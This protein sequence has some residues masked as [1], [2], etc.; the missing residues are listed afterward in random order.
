MVPEIP[1]N[2]I[3]ETIVDLKKQTQKIKKILS[4]TKDKLDQFK[5]FLTL[6]EEKE[7]LIP[8]NKLEHHFF[9][10][11]DM[12]KQAEKKRKTIGFKIPKLQK[13]MDLIFKDVPII[14]D[15]DVLQNNLYKNK[16]IYKII[17]TLKKMEHLEIVKLVNKTYVSKHP[18]HNELFD[19]LINPY[20]TIYDV[21]GKMK[22]KHFQKLEEKIGEIDHNV[23]KK[24][25]IINKKCSI[26]KERIKYRQL[27]KSNNDKTMKKMNRLKNALVTSGKRKI[28]FQ[29]LIRIFKTGITKKMNKM[30]RNNELSEKNKTN[31][32]IRIKNLEQY[33]LKT[34]EEFL[35][36]ELEILS[37]KELKKILK[38]MN[39]EINEYLGKIKE[40][41]KRGNNETNVD[42]ALKYIYDKD[43][44]IKN[45]LTRTARA[46]KTIQS[47]HKAEHEK[48]KQNYEDFKKT[49]NSEIKLLLESL[50]S[51]PEKTQQVQVVVPP[52]LPP[53]QKKK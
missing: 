38:T 42:N 31:N 20:K 1:S 26:R 47:A 15:N 33:L 7:Y 3:L 37:I 40:R 44:L 11:L 4:K 12:I 28:S 46:K 23:L 22:N 35:C 19:K 36:D 45:Y 49:K 48:L 43:F 6:I 34:Y 21:M 2:E 41:I 51:G 30:V 24:L 27:V 13:T 18:K 14:P 39:H 5:A 25:E 9:D 16:E 52:P 29:D 32:M 53:P 8:K 50:S 17:E 10:I